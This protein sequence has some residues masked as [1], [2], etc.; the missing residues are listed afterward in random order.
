MLRFRLPLPPVA[1]AG[2]F[3][4]NCDHPPIPVRRQPKSG[5][6]TLLP[7]RFQAFHVCNSVLAHDPFVLIAD[8][9]SATFTD[10]QFGRDILNDSTPRAP[11]ELPQLVQ[12]A[13][14]HTFLLI[15]SRRGNTTIGPSMAHVNRTMLP[16]SRNLIPDQATRCP[17]QEGDS[18]QLMRFGIPTRVRQLSDGR[19]RWQQDMAAGGGALGVG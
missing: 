8:G 1:G 2:L 7:E 5:N 9:L 10:I 13:V 3:R 4:T 15:Q 16:I 19:N 6:T 17:A 14:F 11:E 18:S 12:D